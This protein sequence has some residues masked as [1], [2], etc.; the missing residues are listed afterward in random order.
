MNT[1]PQL[2]PMSLGDLFD[3]AFRLYREHFV[4]FVGIVALLQVPLAIVQ[5]MIQVLVSIPALR[6]WMR[7][8]AQL[9]LALRH[10]GAAYAPRQSQ[11][12]PAGRCQSTSCIRPPK[13]AAGHN[14]T[15]RSRSALP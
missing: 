6:A 13:K 2:R 12:F 9:Q 1:A 14:V 3:T 8:S 10:T 11:H 4:T 7:A 15:R 5:F